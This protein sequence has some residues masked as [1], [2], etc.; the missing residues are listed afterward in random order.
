MRTVRLAPRA[1]IFLESVRDIGYTLATA[2]ADVIDNS[3]AAEAST[4]QLF[5]RVEEGVPQIGIL[6][7]G[8]GMTEGVLYEAMRLGSYNP[9]NRRSPSDLGR[10]GLGLKTA[11]FSQCRRLTVVTRQKNKTSVASW[12]LDL[13]AAE[14]DWIVVIPNDLE[15]VPWVEQLGQHG[16]LVVWE[17]IDRLSGNEINAF[18]SALFNDALEDAVEHIQLVFHR[19]LLGEDNVQRTEISLNNR[20][21]EGFDPFHRTHPATIAEPRERILVRGH[22]V[23]VQ[24]Y[25]L[26]HHSKVEKDSWDRFEGQEG[27][28]RSQGF[29]V[30]RAKRL[31]IHGT[32]FGLAR[33]QELTKLTRVQVDMPNELDSEWKIDIKKSSAQLPYAVRIRLKRIIDRVVLGSRRTYTARGAKLLS[34]DPLPV[35]CREL[36]KNEI[37]YHLNSEHPVLADFSS[38]LSEG[39]RASFDHLLKLCESALPLQTL[40]AD[41]GNQPNNLP[42]PSVPK[43][44]LMNWARATVNRLK[45]AGLEDEEIFEMLKVTEPFRSNWE[46]AEECIKKEIARE[47]EH[48]QSI[49]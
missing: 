23:V 11:S 47:S 4:I 33:Q 30:Y 19:F 49:K 7:D 38:R 24:A 32:W 6:D 20:P 46:V 25:T 40:Y 14:D 15:A 39:L 8:T 44:S 3:I 21:L 35:W 43:E 45:A 27:Y 36:N 9:L 16:T 2:L 1:A 18:D 41:M 37:R 26:P 10:F 13:I 34:G 22:P 12:D 5:S 17:K 31:I 28:L 29:Y 42:I 48:G